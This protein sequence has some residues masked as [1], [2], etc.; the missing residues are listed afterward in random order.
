MENNLFE[1]LIFLFI[2]FSIIQSLLKKKKEEARKREQMENDTAEEQY[3]TPQQQESQSSEIG[4]E[5]ED[6]KLGDY[7]SQTFEDYYPK[8]E[9]ESDNI[10]DRYQARRDLSES[11]IEEDLKKYEKYNTTSYDPKEYQKKRLS[12]FYK[13]DKE[14]AAL[15]K[16]PLKKENLQ[17]IRRVKNVRRKLQ[18]P[19]NLKEYIT[20][21]EILGKPKALRD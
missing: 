7:S 8:T 9:K 13:G 10:E 14:T 19:E 15:D 18:D 16:P 4:D 3:E 1:I 2:G 20:F 5:F 12:S 6:W 21:N 11:K 17:K